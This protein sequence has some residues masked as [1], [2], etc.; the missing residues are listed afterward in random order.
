MLRRHPPLA[1]AGLLVG[2]IVGLVAAAPVFFVSAAGATAVQAQWSRGCPADF[3]PTL[4]TPR[5]VYILPDGASLGVDPSLNR[6]TAA[7]KGIPGLGVP[8]R[9]LANSSPT[10]VTHSDRTALMGFIFRPE[11]L[12]HLEFIGRTGPGDVYIPDTLATALDAAPGD[13]ISVGVGSGFG[14]VVAGVFRDLTQAPLDGYWCAAVDALLPKDMFGEVFPPSMAML[15][16][17][18]ATSGQF[19]LRPFRYSVP[20]AD[21]PR[22]VH[23]ARALTAAAGLVRARIAAQGDTSH[24]ITYS[25]DRLTIRAEAV[26]GAVRHTT[27]PVALLAVGCALASAAVLGGLWMRVRRNTG[28]ALATM[29]I[30]PGAMGAKAAVETFVPVLLGGITGVVIGRATMGVWAPSGTIEPGAMFTALAVAVGAALVA[31]FI[32][33]IAAGA[34]SRSLLRTTVST[35]RS[36]WRY[37][38]VELAFLAVAVW[39]AHSL[40]RQALVP[41]DGRRVLETGPSVL[42]L[43]MSVLALGATLSARLWWWVTARR[44][45]VSMPRHL[46]SRLAVRRLQ[47]NSRVGSA[48]LGVGTLALGVSVFGLMMNSSLARTADAKAALFVGGDTAVLLAGPLPATPGATEVWTRNRMKYAGTPVDVV[49]IDPA[50]FASVAFWDRS[51]ADRDLP[52]LLTDLERANGT[53]AILVGEGPDTG[54]LR[55]PNTNSKPITV[56]VIDRAS[57]FPGASRDRPTLVVTIAEMTGGP[58]SFQHFAWVNGSYNEWRVTLQDLGALPLYGVERKTAVDNSVLR[59]AAW[60]FDFVRALG[61]FVGMLVAIALTLHL[62]ARQRQQALAFAFLRRMG[63]RALTHWRALVFEMAAV[64]SAI[65]IVGVTLAVFSARMVTPYVDPLPT[66]LPDPLTVVP[67]FG[68]AGAFALI[69]LV[70]I[71]G[72]ALAQAAAARVDVSEVLRD[73][74]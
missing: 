10:S 69:A 30:G 29:G 49:A 50:T 12:A 38:P 9:I 73:G 47:F 13:T 7:S 3:A 28:V 42:L 4:R 1:L 35:G 8:E 52:L 23:D 63:M 70:V 44:R 60:S 16:E 57:A 54:E 53:A 45:R 71:G 33:A 24:S 72:T 59:F 25:I 5:V 19:G 51:F 67:W 14:L 48:I 46:A 27:L 21:P 62:A 55:N 40:K 34:A 22:T 56:H 31:V 18:A 65:F 58:I 66:L 43:P 32:T 26:R 64:A 37:V 39:A 41:I 11:A 36:R 68:I 15:T 61:V 17:K 20:F 2:V 6:L 74:T